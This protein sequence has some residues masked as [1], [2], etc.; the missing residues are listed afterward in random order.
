MLAIGARVVAC[1]SDSGEV[2]DETFQ[3]VTSSDRIFSVA[4][5]H[6][7]GFKESKQYDVEGLPQATGAWFGFFRL[8]GEGPIDYELRFYASHEDAVTHGRALAK[9]SPARTRC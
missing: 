6:G 1:D 2:A 5:F 4:D 3:K 8:D 7:A 9:R